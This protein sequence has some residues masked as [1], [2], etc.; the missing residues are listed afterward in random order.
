[1]R[2]NLA[3][4]AQVYLAISQLHQYCT[5]IYIK[6]ATGLIHDT[7]NSNAQYDKS[8]L[9]KAQANLRISTNIFMILFILPITSIA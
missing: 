8:F 1:M 4:L 5:C 6:T 7:D 2:Y 3:L 9:P